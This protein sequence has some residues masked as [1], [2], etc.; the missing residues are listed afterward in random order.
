M[1]VHAPS[2]MAS[3]VRQVF[4]R[5]IRAGVFD[6][7]FLALDGVSSVGAELMNWDAN[8]CASPAESML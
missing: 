6:E 1:A 3:K 7:G 5:S 8:T 2:G 4:V